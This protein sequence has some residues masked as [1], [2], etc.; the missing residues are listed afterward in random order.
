M[1]NLTERL[2][3]KEGGLYDG[4][5]RY[6]MLRADVLMLAMAQMG[7]AGFEAFADA[8]AK[9]GKHSVTKYRSHGVTDPLKL[10]QML[11]ETAS[12]LGWGRWS[13]ARPRE[14]TLRLTVNHSPFVH[15]HGDSETP[16]CAP[17]IGML[18]A[19]GSLVLNGDG[20]VHAEE[21]EC[22]AVS[23]GDAC[24]FVARVQLG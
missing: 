9:G 10:L 17:I 16:V 8:V 13:L 6:V 4:E 2:E 1:A 14:T 15:G 19:T 22:A 20:I 18:R 12:H 24:R 7:E 5:V 11:E 3:R 23:G 21:S